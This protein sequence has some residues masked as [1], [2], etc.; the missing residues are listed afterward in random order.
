M[1]TQEKQLSTNIADIAENDLRERYPEVL[2]VLL[3][4]AAG[5]TAKPNLSASL[6][7]KSNKLQIQ[8]KQL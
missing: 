7:K 6:K 1:T 4:P 8:E 3:L 5:K 2:E